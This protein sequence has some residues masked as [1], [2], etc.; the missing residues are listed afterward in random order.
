MTDREISIRVSAAEAGAKPAPS[1][2][3]ELHKLL[4][5]ATVLLTVLVVASCFARAHYY[6]ELL[7]HFRIHYGVCYFLAAI[8]FAVVKRW[9]ASLIAGL[10]TLP[11]VALVIPFYRPVARPNAVE[12]H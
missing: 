10:A 1:W 2:R 12:P 4:L 8:G 5:A 7:T 3:A 6:C 11:F 9:R